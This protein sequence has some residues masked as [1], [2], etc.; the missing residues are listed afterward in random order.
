MNESER[1]YI[2]PGMPPLKLTK[3]AISFFEFWPTWLIYLPVV[4]CALFW[5]LR[6]RSLTLPL[7][8]NPCIRL[9]GMVGSSKSQLMSQCNDY[10]RSLI[11]PWISYINN[12]GEPIEQQLAEMITAMEAANLKFP[13]VGK[14]DTGC[15]GS[16]VKLLE[17]RGQLANYLSCFPKGATLFLQQLAQWE[18]EVGILYIR[19]PEEKRGKIASMGFKYCPYV[20]G[21]G[22]STLSELINANTRARQLRHLYDSRHRDKLK[23]IIADGQPYRLIFSASHCSGAIFC[24]GND[25]ITAELTQSID[26]IM[27][28]IADFY[29][30]RLDIKFK[31]IESLQLGRN[32]AIIEINGVSSEPV[33]IWDSHA[34]LWKAMHTLIIQYK[35]LFEI[36]AQNRA[37]GLAPHGL[38]EL[39]KAWKNEHKLSALYPSTD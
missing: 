1:Q 21:D 18:P 39:I 38:L 11:L 37:R 22:R 16:G 4:A 25:H 7:I 9:S 12:S 34:S 31:D 10:S 30:G 35:E 19:K 26:K 2:T 36:G 32:F 23:T 20:V 29:F 17:D 8:V 3:K 5:A 6:Y 33:H 14:P 24:D 28:G 15:R 27:G 13:V